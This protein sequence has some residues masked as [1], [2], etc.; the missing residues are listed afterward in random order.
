MNVS[1]IIPIY[2]V[3]KYIIRC[4]RSLLNQTYPNI[5]YIFVDDYT[6]D[7][8]IVLLN[9]VI[10]EYPL[11]K[12]DVKIIH[13]ESNLGL[14]AARNSGIKVATG[15][16]IYHCDSDDF[17]E[18]E[19][20]ENLVMKAE[21][22]DAD[23]VWCDYYLTYEKTE[24]YMKQPDVKSVNEAMVETLSG[25]MKYNVWNKLVRRSLYSDYNIVFPSGYGMGEDMTMIKLLT[26]AKSVAYIPRALYHYNR[27]NISAFTQTMSEKHLSDVKH[28]TDSTIAFVKQVYG[29]ELNYYISLFQLEVKL[30]LLMTDNEECYIE[31]LKW[32][33]ESHLY[34]MKN[35]NI[36]KRMRYVQYMASKHQ[37]WFVKMHFYMHGFIYRMLYQ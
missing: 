24:R 14:A 20:I 5:E 15:K 17:L 8:S 10:E 9:E 29:D 6:S 13:H 22:C 27:T 12:K 32:F 25:T 2:N 23:Y 4:A 33:P 18:K 3:E 28:N 31:W 19:M 7:N 30:P 1:V 35:T 26:V 37:F 16:Y 11:R 36:S 34:I 21:M